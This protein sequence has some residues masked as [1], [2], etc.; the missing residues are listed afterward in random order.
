[1]SLEAPAVMNDPAI[2]N[3]RSSTPP[4]DDW[5]AFSRDSI[6]YRQ[7]QSFHEQHQFRC[8]VET[9]TWKGHTTVALAGIFPHVYTIE[10]LPDRFEANKPRFQAYENITAL[11]G[12]SPQVLLTLVKQFEF[13]LFAFLDAHWQDNWPLRDELKILLSIRQPKLIMIHDFKVPG[14]DFGYDRYGA[15]ECALSHIADLLP[16]DECKYSFNSYAAPQSEK[17]GV[18]FIEH[19][20][21]PSSQV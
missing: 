4:N 1:M 13:P 20:L 9:G 17:R 2:M 19:L 7:V 5:A 18:I 11:I 3:D 15:Q 6:L 12:E 21:Y 8:A 16:H 14:R 10:I